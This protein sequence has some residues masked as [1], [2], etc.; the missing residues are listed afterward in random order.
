M[1]KYTNSAEVSPDGKWIVCSYREDAN[2]TWRYAIIPSEG[3]EPSKVFDLLGKKG[4]FRWS[5]DG[6]SLNYLR[7]TQGGVTNVWSL[8]LDDKPPKQLTDF[9]TDRIFNFAWSPDGKQLV[10]ARGVTTSDVVLISDF[11]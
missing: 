6:R 11:E 4:N 2:S 10:L 9:K 7:D 1:D 3:G 5:P 8:P